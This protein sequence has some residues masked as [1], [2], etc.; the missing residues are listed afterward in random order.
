M[1]NYFSIT[2]DSDYPTAPAVQVADS[3]CGAWTTHNL[4]VKVSLEKPSALDAT[5]YKIWGINGISTE[6]S[7]GWVA[8][9]GGAHATVTGTLADSSAKQTIYAK[10]KNDGVSESDIV[11]ASGVYF[12]WTDPTID[13]TTEWAQAFSAVDYD[14]A[15]SA[16][17][18]NT[19]NNIS[20]TLS[21]S[22]LPGLSFNSIDLS[23]LSIS[24]N[25]IVV[26]DSS[27]FAALVN[28]RSGNKVGVQKVFSED[29][30]PL[31]TVDAGSGA[32]TLTA[33]DG[34]VKSTL[35]G[36]DLNR[37]ENYSYTSGTKTL[38]FD[39]KQF[40]T[41]GFAT[42]NKVEFDST[43]NG[44]YNGGSINIEVTVTDTNNE[45]V[46][47]APVTITKASGDTIGSFSSNPVNTN[48]SGIASFTLNLSSI[49]TCV[50]DAY[51]DSVHTVNDLTAWCIA[52]PNPQRSLL[53]QY[54]QIRNTATYDD[55]VANANTSAVAEP[56]TSTVSGS[57]DSVLEH[58]MNVIRTLM[59]QF[60][61]TTNWYDDLGMYFDP[62]TTDSGS[63]N[64]KQMS[65][66]NV[67]G[68]TLDS[69][70][71]ILAV[72][73]DDSGNGYDVSTGASGI[74]W[75]T[76]LPYAK[77]TNRRGLPI[78]ASTANP[79]TYWDIGGTDDVCRIDLIDTSTG[80][81]FQDASGN[82]VY[83]KF[84]DG[85]DYPTG[86][87][88]GEL[89]DVYVRFYTVSGA[90]TWASGDPS[91]ISFVYP[92]RKVMNELE[93]YEWT[94]TDFVSS[95][96][97]D[98]E[99]VED[100]TNLWSFTGAVDDLTGPSFN[101]TGDYYLVG[102]LDTDLTSAVDS[103]NTGLGDF[104]YTEQNYV[105][106][107]ESITSSLDE[108]DMAAKDLS[109]SVTSSSG[110]RYTEELS[111]DV[112]AGELHSLPYSITYT[113]DATVG[114]EGQNMDVYVNGQ[115]LAASS[116]LNGA[117]EDRDY[118]ETTAS[119]ITFHFDVYSG[120]NVVYMVRQ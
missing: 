10:F 18:R 90:Y 15:S 115:L 28:R 40:S 80:A 8:W 19:N 98:A 87:G 48:A 110:D 36:D 52:T 91:N 108:L 66:S 49:G 21:K 104:T 54:E 118:A 13:G 17:L 43:T 101:N 57:S 65:L 1:A 3:D 41:Y 114:Q 32:Y 96:E 119:G 34:S 69:K 56:T 76:T 23:G 46:E 50:F 38:T 7:A 42:I 82:E 14:A 74:L 26:N 106:D 12:S 5:H 29:N 79:N 107:N 67:K 60:T 78:Y 37:V 113:P 120:T 117:N 72:S 31:I 53:T 51:V 102:V 77:N 92:F 39:V 83:A 85:A 71:I 86:S 111:G 63:S 59:K 20:I 55:A 75:T 105:T 9:P 93:E 62:T 64:T 58:D 89:T 25:K 97:G 94:R 47:S 88:T 22:N 61:G 68:N 45:G 6:G 100:V 103:I 95:W 81:E 112:N 30:Q 16:T 11:T 33:Y 44:G 73:E 2:I 27:D 84:H 109:D 35:T 24:G 4:Q 99:L 116:G 70:T